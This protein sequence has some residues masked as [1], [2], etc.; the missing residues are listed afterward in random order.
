MGTNMG[1]NRKIETVRF[2]SQ[3]GAEECEPYPN[4]SMVS[5]TGWS[6]FATDAHIKPGFH[7]LLRLTFD[8]VDEESLDVPVGSIP[9]FAPDGSI[10]VSGHLLPDLRHA[11][12]IVA[13]IEE[14]VFAH[15]T[16]HCYAGQSR[17]AAV[18]QFVAEKYGADLLLQN[19]IV[20]TRYKNNRLYRLLN[21]T[22]SERNK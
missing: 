4:T 5:I 18:A 15:L 2:L 8:D 12:E 3:S 6:S 13:F 20:G 14:G 11:R 22:Y 16:V 7:S 1:N 9:D 19:H 21:K 10:I 17:S